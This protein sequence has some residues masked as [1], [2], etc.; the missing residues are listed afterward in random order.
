MAILTIS[1]AISAGIQ[2]NVVVS[3][4][5]HEAKVRD[6]KLTLAG[7]EIL[8][9]DVHTKRLTDARLA[10]YAYLQGLTP[11][12]RTVYDDSMADLV[13]AITPPQTSN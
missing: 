10:H 11:A 8:R 4:L 5:K 7:E 9:M 6:L 2:R 1:K 3:T 13:S 12:E